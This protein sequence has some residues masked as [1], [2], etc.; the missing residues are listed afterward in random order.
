MPPYPFL[1]IMSMHW[2]DWSLLLGL[3]VVLTTLLCQW[4]I[5][6][7]LLHCCKSS[8]TQSFS[9]CLLSQSAASTWSILVL[10]HMHATADFV[11]R[12]AR[13]MSQSSLVVNVWDEPMKCL[14]SGLNAWDIV[15]WNSIVANS[16][17]ISAI[18]P[19]ILPFFCLFLL[20]FFKVAV[21]P[22]TIKM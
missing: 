15:Q 1:I 6:T 2:P 12:N 22:K 8:S 20:C 10:D 21:N 16:L 7:T 17:W 9:G 19:G 4:A 14:R 13:Y 5:Y 3:G 18:C 11:T